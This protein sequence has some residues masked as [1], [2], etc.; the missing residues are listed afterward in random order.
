MFTF[1]SLTHPTGF[2]G[3]FLYSK[4]HGLFDLLREHTFSIA[5]LFALFLSERH[6]RF[7]RINFSLLIFEKLRRA[8][9]DLWGF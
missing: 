5:A 8:Q 9:W 3:V 1:Y 4:L 2:G 6:L 7:I